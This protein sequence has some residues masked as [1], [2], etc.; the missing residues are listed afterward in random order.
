[1]LWLKNNIRTLLILIPVSLIILILVNPLNP[2]SNNSV[3]SPL[4]ANADAQPSMVKDETVPAAE[5]SLT[6]IVDV[7]GAVHSPGVYEVKEGD[8]VTDALKLAGGE[9]READMKFVNLS[10]KLQDEM[11]VYVPEAGEDVTSVPA[12]SAAAV[13]ATGAGEQPQKINI[14]TAD[15]AELQTITGIG[16]AKAEAILAY[17]ET[18]GNFESIEDIKNISGIGDKTFD[19]LKESIDV[20]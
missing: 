5:P 15:A 1:M 8:R 3:P 7:K 6:I 13:T 17:R 11:V 10:Q 12:A 20:K 9:T 19:K 2:S 14:N 18:E 16:P 4:P